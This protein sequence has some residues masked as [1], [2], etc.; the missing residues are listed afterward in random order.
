MTSELH[1]PAEWANLWYETRSRLSQCENPT[2]NRWN[3]DDPACA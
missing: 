3:V 1:D 2:F